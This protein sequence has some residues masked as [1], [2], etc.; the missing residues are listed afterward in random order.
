[1]D[2]D[3]YTIPLFDGTNFSNWKY[4][5]E[6]QLEEHDLLEFTEDDP[7]NKIVIQDDDG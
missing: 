2:E 6:V 7:I 4:R 3:K 5:M 1:M